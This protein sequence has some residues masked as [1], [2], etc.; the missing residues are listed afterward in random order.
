M[1][2]IVYL[3]ETGDHSLEA[4][5]K[6]FPIFGL[7]MLV[8]DTNVYVHSIVPAVYQ[9]KIDFF[10]H[11]GV[12]LHS[13]DIRKQKNEFAILNDVERRTAFYERINSVMGDEEYKLIA[14][15]IRKQEHKDSY[16]A[17]EAPRN[18]YDLALELALEKLLP[19]LT[20][21]QQTEVQ[22][23]AEA[24]GKNEDDDLRQS[25]RD[26]LREGSLRV[27][28]AQFRQ[29]QYNLWFLP[30]S[31]NIVGTQLTDLAAYPMARRVIDPSKPNPAYDILR[32]KFDLGVGEESGIIISP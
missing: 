6:T 30:K 2:L 26:I 12:I 28:A 5:D 14:A 21:A 18:P 16:D 1:P 24:R 23:V 29:V 25:L 4:I 17:K 20:A 27:S 32:P 3:D 8:C 7:V 22:I 15:V 19:L 11:E 31:M 10:G 13:Y 9:L